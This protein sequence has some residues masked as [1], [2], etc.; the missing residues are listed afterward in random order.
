MLVFI[1]CNVKLTKL[2]ECLLP[3]LKILQYRDV[4]DRLPVFRNLKWLELGIARNLYWNGLLFAFLNFSPVLETLV[5]LQVS[6]WLLLLFGIPS[7]LY[8]YIREMNIDDAVI[9]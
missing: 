4:K 3:C 5:F 7:F 8:S 1:Y 9:L 6:V 2:P